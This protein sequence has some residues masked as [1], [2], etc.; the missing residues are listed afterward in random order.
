MN[1]TIPQLTT[2]GN[3]IRANTDVNGNLGNIGAIIDAYNADSSFFVWRENVPAGELGEV[4]DLSNVG[5]L[6]S[7]NI[8]R[9][10][11]AFAIVNSNG[12]EFHGSREDHRAFFEDVFSGAAGNETR[13]AVL[14]AWQRLATLA[15][16]LFATGTGTECTE[17]NSDGTPSTGSPGDL[18]VEGQVDL[19]N[20]DQALEL[21][22]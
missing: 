19:S 3:H 11:G 4:F 18:V 9:L 20:I 1:L 15:E 6:T 7:A 21:T 2:L 12:G 22:A 5:N 14:S 16:S 8:E 13:P 17:L 10:T